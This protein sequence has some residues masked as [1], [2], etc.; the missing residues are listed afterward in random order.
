[1]P[2]ALKS[3]VSV[4]LLSSDGRLFG[5]WN[6]I[7]A[8]CA[9]GLA[10]VACGI[11]VVQSGWHQTSGQVIEGTQ[12]IQYTV[13]MGGVKAL[14]PERMIKAG[15][16]VSLSVRNQP[17]GDVEVTAVSFKPKQEVIPMASGAYKVVTDPTESHT[18]DI[19]VTLKDTATQTK[20]GYVAN[21]VKLKSGMKMTIEAPLA[22]W[23]GVVTDIE[24][25]AT[26]QS[27][28]TAAA[29]Q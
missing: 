1:M 25:L 9:A 22:Y 3:P 21:G 17:R 18:V 28:A 26:A 20:T 7:D 4:G 6:V 5:R 24:L 13:F 12:A 11:V 19:W 15:D 8:V 29:V 14:H 16:R 23:S 27:D 10:L 2:N